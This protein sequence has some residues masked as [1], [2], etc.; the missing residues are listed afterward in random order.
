[1]TVALAS[2][3]PDRGVVERNPMIESHEYRVELVGSD[4]KTG[5][6]KAKSDGLPDLAVSSPPQFG[7]PPHT[8]SPEHL[9][10]ASVAGCLM[11]T[12]RSIAARSGVEVLEYTDEATGIL[13]K[14]PEGLYSIE[15]VVLR[16]TIVITDDSNRDRAQRLIERAEEVCLIGRS[17]DCLVVLEA[18]VVQY[19]QVG[20]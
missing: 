2:G 9:F 3:V 1:M 4:E 20:T 15:Q 11:T 18:R 17:I 6:L 7:G 12:F 10:V 8:W 5:M 16:P 19:H 14:G 13:R